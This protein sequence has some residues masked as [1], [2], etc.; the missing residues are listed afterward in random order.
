M[1]APVIMVFWMASAA[2]F[3][4]PPDGFRSIAVQEPR[5]PEEKIK[6]LEAE[7]TRLREELSALKGGKPPVV[8]QPIPSKDS[9]LSMEK[10][11][12]ADLK[13]LAGMVRSLARDVEAIKKKVGIIDDGKGDVPKTSSST[14]GVMRFINL[15]GIDTTAVVNGMPIDVPAGGAAEVNVV[16]VV[17]YSVGGAPP[18][19]IYVPAGTLRPMT[20]YWPARY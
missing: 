11:S 4:A 14:T 20:I 10:D 13:A 8:L 16:G 2:A 3:A 5:T 1:K 6:Q 7:I 17:Q 19:S 12:D 18:Q 15:L 9:N